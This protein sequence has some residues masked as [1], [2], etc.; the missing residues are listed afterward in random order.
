MK[1]LSFIRQRSFARYVAID[2]AE[3]AR[4][5]GWSVLWIDIEGRLL[6]SADRTPAEREAVVS[7]ILDEIGAFD[8]HLVFSYGLEYF[9]PVFKDFA[10]DREARFSELLRRPAACFCFDFGFPFDRPVAELTKPYIAAL[11]G[12]GAFAFCWDQD[13]IAR[14][15]EYG[16]IKT[17]HFPMAVNPRLFHRDQEEVAGEPEIPVLF[18]G[19]PDADRNRCLAGLAGR[20]LQIYG[21]DRARWQE[22]LRRCHAGELLDR[23]ALRRAYNRARIS[24]NVTRAHGK[25]SL[26]MRVYEAMACGA[27]M[28]TDQKADA[29]AL[30]RDGTELVVYDGERDLV[31]KVEYYLAHEDERSRIADAGMRKVQAGHTYDARIAEVAPVLVQLFSEHRLFA[32]LDSFARADTEKALAFV[33]FLRDG[34]RVTGSADLLAC[35]AAALSL[36]RGDRAGAIDEVRAALAVNPVH[37]EALA[38]ADRLGIAAPAARGAGS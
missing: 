11:Q 33:R 26:N 12:E 10:P 9:E 19:G 22:A 37:L 17:R 20:G 6:A 36:A 4:T 30:F 5:L 38:L 34:S 14:M 7:A 1:V 13:A 8:P 29:H 16:V 2:L 28:L 24:V 3:S 25:S 21:Y 35:R 23:P 18:V 31:E 15:R 32:T 27:L